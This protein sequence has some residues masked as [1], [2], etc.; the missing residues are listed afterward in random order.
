MTTALAAEAAV[1]GRAASSVGSMAVKP[2]TLIM[3]GNVGRS[4]EMFLLLDPLFLL[5]MSNGL[6]LR[7]GTGVAVGV[8][9]SFCFRPSSSCWSHLAD[10]LS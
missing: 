9:S 10:C 4:I 6:S 8:S 7:L 3:L 1:V 2:I 5:E